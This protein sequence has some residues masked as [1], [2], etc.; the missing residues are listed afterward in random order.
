VLTTLESGVQ[1]LGVK[2]AGVTGDALV[3]A[4]VCVCCAGAAHVDI[5]GPCEPVTHATWLCIGGQT[6]G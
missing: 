4:S 2:L 1:L 6:G 3:G 5:K